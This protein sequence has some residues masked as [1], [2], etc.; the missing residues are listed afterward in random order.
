LNTDLTAIGSRK[1]F[2]GTTAFYVLTAVPFLMIPL[3]VLFRRKKRQRDSDVVGNRVRTSNRLA[4]KYL[5]DA[6]RNI[7]DKE[8]FYIALEKAMH[9][10]LKAKLHIE[11]SEMSKE[12][13]HEILLDRGADSETVRDFIVLTENCDFARYAP[14]SAGAIQ[15]D[16]GKAISIISE[17]EKQLK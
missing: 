13:I 4:R 15:H 11:T 8:Q 12:K 7:N 14:A 5:S 1:S 2:F 17:L 6:K 9:N 10:F 3:L 16:Y